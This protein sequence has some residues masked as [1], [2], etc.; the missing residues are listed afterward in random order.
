MKSLAIAF[1][2]Y[3][4]PSTEGVDLRGPP[5]P[6]GP[7]GP[8]GEISLVFGRWGV[9]RARGPEAFYEEAQLLPSGSQPAL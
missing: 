5:G 7:R 8:P 3:L 2:S 1:W 4:L 9:L 6:P